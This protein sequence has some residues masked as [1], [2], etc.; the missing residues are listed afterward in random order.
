MADPSDTNLKNIII[1]IYLPFRLVTV[2]AKCSAPPSA[3]SANKQ[4]K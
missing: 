3:I 1:I 4:Q 2:L